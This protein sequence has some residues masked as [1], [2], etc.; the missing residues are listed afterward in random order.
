MSNIA[1]K[2]CVDCVT[3]FYA[4]VARFCYSTAV[5]GPKILLCCQAGERESTL[6]K[7]GDLEGQ[8]A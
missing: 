4:S 3:S 1:V 2:E 6:K 5:Q 8:E 7:A